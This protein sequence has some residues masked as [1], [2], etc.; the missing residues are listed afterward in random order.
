MSK[1]ELMALKAANLKKRKAL[2][3]DQLRNYDASSPRKR[4]VYFLRYPQ[5]WQDF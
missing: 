4:Q 2:K 5:Q 3:V 1:V